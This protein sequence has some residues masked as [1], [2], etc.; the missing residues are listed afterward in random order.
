MLRT[1]G[2]AL[3]ALVMA[4]GVLAAPAWGASGAVAVKVERPRALPAQYEGGCPAT[5]EFVARV[6]VRGATRLTYRWVR[7]DGGK[8]PV[9]TVGVKGG[10]VLLRDV[11]TFGSSTSGWQA[12]QVLSPRR[13]T[14]AKA[15]FAVTCLTPGK[16]TT[17]QPGAGE[18]VSAYVAAP[19]RYEGACPLPGHR[20]TF[21]GTIKGGAV[22]YRW[23]DSDGGPQPAERLLSGTRV[24]STRTFLASA[25]GTRHLEV[26]D[27][28]GRV[29]HRSN[30]VAYQV[31]CSRP[32]QEDPARAAVTSPRVMPDSYQGPCTGPL[33]FGFQ[34]ELAVTKPTKVTYQWVRSDGVK[35][36]GEIELKAGDLTASI[37]M[38]WKVAEPAK[39]PRGSARLQVLT[40]NAATTVPV[41]FTITCGA[42]VELGDTAVSMYSPQNAPCSL[43]GNPYWATAAVNVKAPAG[44]QASYRW[45]WA[46]GGY[47]RAQDVTLLEDQTLRYTWPVR[48]SKVGSAWLEV[49][50]ASGT[51]R[52]K[53]AEVSVIC[54]GKPLADA[55]GTVLAVA[56]EVTPD[57]YHGACPTTL[58]FSVTVTVSAPLKEPVRYVWFYDNSTSSGVEELSFPEGGPL[59]RT[60][61]VTYH[62]QKST[63]KSTGWVEVLSP[64]TMLSDQVSY[65]V[66]CS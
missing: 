29:I 13:T 1:M 12:V 52:S 3:A 55:G 66:T 27:A 43:T 28:A 60:A 16:V 14:S 46:D 19:E 25:S 63:V 64:T 24:T 30:R 47:T 11:R 4:T 2:T 8:G 54:D 5:T 35:V 26:L 51:V 10:A 41:T 31:T 32:P 44:T 6:S 17:S 15:R 58:T 18:R 37:A 34:A 36:P 45:R 49:T 57:D 20:V 38:V 53:P 61:T 56:G 21:T 50:T 33:E 42:D 22:R 23:V 39:L 7:G 40:P 48:F 65:K 59:T 9:R 62:P